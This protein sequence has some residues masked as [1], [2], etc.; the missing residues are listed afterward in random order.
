MFLAEKIYMRDII[1]NFDLKIGFWLLMRKLCSNIRYLA[2]EE[3]LRDKVD[4]HII[5]NISKVEKVK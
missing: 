4:P 5:K 1:K 2:K 3:V